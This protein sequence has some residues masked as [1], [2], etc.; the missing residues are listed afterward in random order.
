MNIGR[1]RLAN[2]H[3]SRPTFSD[4]ADVVRWLGAVQAQDYLGGLWAVGL[5]TKGATE[6]TVEEAIAHRAIV[7]TWPMR[8]TLHFVA[9]DDV[10]WILPILTPRV[11][12]GAQSRFR[13]LG[14]DDATFTKSARVAEKALAGGSIVR[15]DRLYE[16]WNAAGIATHDARGLHLLGVLSQ[17]GLLCFGPRDGKQQTFTLLEE[18]LPSSRTLARADA[19]GE[20]ARRYFRSHGP[21]TV[22]DFA[23]WSGLTVTEARAGLECVQAELKSEDVD[24]R[25]FWFADSPAVRGRADTAYLLPPWDEFTVAYRDRSD[26]LDPKYGKRVNAGGGVLSPVIVLRGVVVG[27]WQRTIK[28]DTVTVKPALFKALRR[29][30]R[31]AVAKAVDRYS[32]F[33]GLSAGVLAK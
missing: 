7:R 24:G 2:Q 29:V 19:L 5:R 11:V 23:W 6:A 14:M 25:T 9:A 27:T 1:T 12:A 18:W 17:Q 22:H 13:Q 32:R 28:K 3:V 4:P 10:R 15:R 31:E 26:I 16:I 30:D 8:G 21:A 33:L 20:L